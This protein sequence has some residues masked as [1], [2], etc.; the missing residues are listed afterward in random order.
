MRRRVFIMAALV[1][2][3][4]ALGS[5]AVSYNLVLAGASA[6]GLWS[7]IGVG[8]DNAMKTAYP[9]STVTYQTS[10]GGYANVSLLADEKV[11]IAILH[12]AEA[13]KAVEGAAPFSKPSEHLRAL[14]VLYD[15]SAL[16]PI[17]VKAFA[18]EHG[19]TSF[20]DLK[21]KRP[22]LRLVLNKPGNITHDLAVNVLQA[23]GIAPEDIESWGG[24]VMIAGSRESAEL[25]R[26]G[27]ADMAMNAPFVGH[28]SILEVA[29]ARELILLAPSASVIGSVG[30]KMGIGSVTI[31]ASAYDWLDKDTPTLALAAMIAADASMDDVTA[32]AITAALIEHIDSLRDVHKA[33]LGLDRPMLLRQRSIP[34]HPGSIAAFKEAG[35]M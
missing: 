21:A 30:E 9:G 6:G 5:A 7:L 3:I 33:M 12:D 19:I 18:E 28:S 16:Q 14:A 35:L 31:P 15:F 1:A 4:P 34:F 24:R 29:S 25:L 22:P 26:N 11:D 8:V 27:Q 10:G 23:Y 2:M 32:K 13:R 20:E 17:L